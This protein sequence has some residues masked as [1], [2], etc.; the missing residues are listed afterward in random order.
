MLEK[1]GQTVRDVI[2]MIVAY[3][4]RFGDSNEARNM[5][6]EMFKICAGLEFENVNFSNY[7]LAQVFDPPSDKTTF[8]FYCHKCTKMVLH[9][10]TKKDIKGQILICKD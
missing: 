3:S 6:I 10:C 9:S 7:K 1:S 8:H 5:L 2:E 4:L